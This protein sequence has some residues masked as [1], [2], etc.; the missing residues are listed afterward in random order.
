M[1]YVQSF[2]KKCGRTTTHKVYTEDFWGLKGGWRL[3]G[4]IASCGASLIASDT[5]SVCCSCGRKICLD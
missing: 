1:A 4:A 5:Y 3:F 2:C